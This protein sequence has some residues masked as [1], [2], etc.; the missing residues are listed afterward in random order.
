MRDAGEV[1]IAVGSGKGVLSD[2]QGNRALQFISK[3]GCLQ[4]EPYG[5][6]TSISKL[7][8]VTLAQGTI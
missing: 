8:A 2:K 7:A 1:W 6:S 5:T 4:V 3:S